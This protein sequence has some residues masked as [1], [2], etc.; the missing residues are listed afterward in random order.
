MI[1]HVP[2]PIERLAQRTRGRFVAWLDSLCAEGDEPIVITIAVVQSAKAR[3][4]KRATPLQKVADR[5][6]AAGGEL[7]G[8]YD[9]LG[10]RLGM[11]KGAAYRALNALAAMGIVT[12]AVSPL[13][14]IV[15][16]R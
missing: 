6:V 7:E 5:I 14:T 1:S 13:G 9:T 16:A 15:Q 10:Q 8:S 3:G 11:S 2:G 4:R 12:L